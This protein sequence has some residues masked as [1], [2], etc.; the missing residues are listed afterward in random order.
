[1]GV[2]NDTKLNILKTKNVKALYA[3]R[4]FKNFYGFYFTIIYVFNALISSLF[5]KLGLTCLVSCFQDSVGI[6]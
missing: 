6:V 4:I 5:S 3:T 2:L 1:M